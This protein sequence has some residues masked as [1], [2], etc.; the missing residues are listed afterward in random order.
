MELSTGEQ[1][2]VLRSPTFQGDDRLSNAH[3]PVVRLLD[4]SEQILDL[5]ETRQQHI[6]VIRIVP[7]E[8]RRERPSAFFLF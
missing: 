8:E 2:F 6:R 3:R 4:G 1:A 5:S 7:K